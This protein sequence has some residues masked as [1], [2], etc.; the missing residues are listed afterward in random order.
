MTINNLSL[1]DKARNQEDVA[2]SEWPQNSVGPY[3]PTCVLKWHR[4][5]CIEESD[6]VDMVENPP[7][8][9]T[10]SP[11]L[12]HPLENIKLIEPDWDKDLESLNYGIRLPNDKRK[13]KT[14]MSTNLNI[15][16]MPSCW[17][18]NMREEKCPTSQHSPKYIPMI[19]SPHQTNQVQ[20]EDFWPPRE[21]RDPKH[22][23]NASIKHPWSPHNATAT[24]MWIH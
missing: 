11:K 2:L 9:Q 22:G 3:S 1:S 5:L 4:C 14:L 6:W 8:P 12:G 19:M 18:I 16:G 13:P 23:H 21:E 24:C 17:P 10:S 15:I 20:W 7:M